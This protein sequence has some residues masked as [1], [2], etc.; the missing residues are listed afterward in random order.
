M[1]VSRETEDIARDLVRHQHDHAPVRDLNREEDRHL[2]RAERIAGDVARLVGSWTFLLAEAVVVAAWILLNGLGLRRWDG[3]P[4]GLLA[5][6]LGGQALAAV[7]VVLMVLNRRYFRERLRAQQEF[8]QEV[9]LEEELKAIMEH[10]ERQDEM[11]LQLLHRLDR[12]ERELR[13]M[14]RQLGGELV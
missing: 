6:V 3:Y 8:E 12:S 13:R 4:F 5:L 9:K 11:L 10:L 14:Q 1:S 7:T 2:G